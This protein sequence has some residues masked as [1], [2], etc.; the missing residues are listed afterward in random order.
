MR[1]ARGGATCPH[2]AGVELRYGRTVPPSPPDPVAAIDEVLAAAVA[3][4]V[5]SAAAAAAGAADRA[6]TWWHGLTRAVPTPGVPIGAATP[7]DLASLTKPMA[8]AAIA[9]ALVG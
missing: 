3:D 7:F 8:T 9:M 4:G 6:W 2:T 1:P 5:C